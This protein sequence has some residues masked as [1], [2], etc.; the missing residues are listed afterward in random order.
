MPDPQPLRPEIKPTSS[1]TLCQVL[2]PLRHNGN[3][4]ME[5]FFAFLFCFSLPEAYGSP[6]ARDQ[7]QRWILNP[8]RGPG[9]KHDSQ[10]PRDI[11]HSDPTVPQQELL[12]LSLI[13]TS[14]RSA[15]TSGGHPLQHPN[16]SDSQLFL[17]SFSFTATSRLVIT[18]NCPAS[19]VANWPAPLGPLQLAS[20]HPSG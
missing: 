16:L 11:A 6:Q 19:K 4:Q 3:S 7:I 13:P 5:G 14:S 18:C 15:L 12:V 2:N 1:W 10:S 9:I 17:H 20:Q 8:L